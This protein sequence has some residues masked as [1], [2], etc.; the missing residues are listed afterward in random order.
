MTETNDQIA[1]PETGRREFFSK[2]AIAA[3]AAAVAG[4][5]ISSRAQAANGDTVVTGF[6]TTGTSTTS[7]S[8]GTSLVV[9][10]GTSR[11]HLSIPVSIY[12]ENTAS[13]AGIGVGGY[14][15]GSIGIG[16]AGVADGTLGIGVYG[17]TIGSQGRGVYGYNEG[18]GGV[19]LYG[20]HNGAGGST[21]YPGTG[22]IGVS[23][24]GT[25]VIASGTNF[26]LQALGSGKIGLGSAGTVTSTTSASV[27]T[28]ARDAD[29]NM[30]VAVANSD[31]RK[32]AGPESAG[33]LHL[34]PTPTRVYDSRAG[35]L[36][37][38]G[39]KAPLTSGSRT[40][41]CTRNSSG[42]P[43]DAKGVIV[44]VTVLWTS[45]AGYVAVT[46]GGAGDTGTSTANSPGAGAKTASSVTVGCGDG[47]K[48]DVSSGSGA[49]FDFIVD[50]N[51]YY[52]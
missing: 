52:V 37:N 17:K 45:A 38:V 42:V 22:V 14:A 47:A 12:G 25:G 3:A 49:A 8:G 31:W 11:T 21:T 10:D 4:V 35:K 32:V 30:W 29:G 43:A 39:T 26:D 13:T 7:L 2:A 33:T 18:S 36:P 16:V 19:G 48:I 9:T 1:T 46:P 5:S 34:L 44:N 51:G 20:E 50:V 23:D 27:G 41:N 28:L 40:I 15:A 6:N 24:A